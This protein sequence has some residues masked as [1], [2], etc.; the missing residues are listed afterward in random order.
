MKKHLVVLVLLGISLYSIATDSSNT[1]TEVKSNNAITVDGITYHLVVSGADKPATKFLTQKLQEITGQTD[2]TTP[3]IGAIT[4]KVGDS[5]PELDKIHPCGYVMKFK[6]SKNIILSGRNALGT[7]YAVNDFLK[8]FAGYRKF[9]GAPLQEIVPR[10]KSITVSASFY[11]KEEPS[12]QSYAV[13]WLL[14][15]Y[16]G[17]SS[18]VCFPGG[19]SFD[20]II[21][22]EQFGETHPEYYPM[23]D[24]K[25]VK[26]KPKMTG[27][28][29]PCLDNPK[30]IELSLVYAD[31]YLKKNPAALSIPFVVNDGGGDCQCE[32]CAAQFAKYGNQ[33][34]NYYNELAKEVKKRYPNKLVSLY[35]YGRCASAAPV[36]VKMEY[37]LLAAC[38]PEI[39]HFERP[40]GIPTAV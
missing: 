28:W 38:R 34:A 18:R 22:V 5:L 2:F 35:A 36:N 27:T 1:L 37:N 14:N 33:Y 39:F 20:K 40:I 32:Y 24:G 16:F 3:L 25:R 10:Q 19:H 31:N 26:L 11:F 17:R 15:S 29:Q 21:P 6:D 12:I 7:M 9:G 13:A 23:I 30:L 8:R 4:I